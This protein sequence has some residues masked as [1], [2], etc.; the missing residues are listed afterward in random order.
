MT[1][2][3]T[4]L[5]LVR[6]GQTTW[7]LEGRLQG[8]LDSPL[9]QQGRV[10]AEKAGDALASAP[11]SRAYA[12]PL[13]R[14]METAGLIVGSRNI[15]ITPMESLKEIGLGLLEGMSLKEAE[16]THPTQL[17]KFWN[18]PHTFHLDGAETVY[19]VQERV[20]GSITDISENNPGQCL[21]LV[22]HA[23]AIKTALAFFLGKEL[24]E[25][26]DVILPGNGSIITL[27]EVKGALTLLNPESCTQ[28]EGQT[29]S[30]TC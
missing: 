21:L 7:N 18:Q 17:T 16:H 4:T 29:A 1:P 13:G 3:P 2:S 10:Q 6:H 20:L 5:Y 30:L 15:P 24:S 25:M 26:N 22:S 12:S 19:Q 14:A 23:I 9:T 27:Q 28:P 11:I 8:H